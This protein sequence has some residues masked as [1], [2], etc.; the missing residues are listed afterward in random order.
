MNTITSDLQLKNDA[1]NFAKTIFDFVIDNKYDSLTSNFDMQR[2]II[3][4]SFYK[5]YVQNRAETLVRELESINFYDNQI[6]ENAP[7]IGRL[8][9]I[10]KTLNNFQLAVFKVFIQ[11]G[12]ML[13]GKGSVTSVNSP[14]QRKFGN[15]KLDIKP[16]GRD[17]GLLFR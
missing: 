10:Q 14:L 6:Y 11:D 3:N 13:Q 7:D 9:K 12:K 2:D 16:S 15:N 4:K 17:Y 1:N 8:E 5:N